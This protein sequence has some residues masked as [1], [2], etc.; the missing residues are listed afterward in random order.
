MPKDLLPPS[1]HLLRTLAAVPVSSAVLDLGCGAGRHTEPIL[2]LGFPVH[3]VDPEADAVEAVRARI[4]DLVGEETAAT[5]TRTADLDDLHDLPDD[6]FDWVIAYHAERY[7]QTSADLGRLLKAARRTTKPGGWVYVSMPAAAADVEAKTQA[8]G[9]GAP[10]S[11]TPDEATDLEVP[12]ISGVE[13]LP[14]DAAA[15]SLMSLEARR[16]D[17]KLE[18]SVRPQLIREHDQPRLR[19]IYRNVQRNPV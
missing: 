1:N 3:A 14:D 11:G 5:C 16:L 18:I 10:P 17:A 12:A 13:A 8:A 19:A 2:R 4:T 15:F 6:A 7:A 9:D